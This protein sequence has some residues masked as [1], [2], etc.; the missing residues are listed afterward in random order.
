MQSKDKQAHEQ[1][2]RGIENAIGVISVLSHAAEEAGEGDFTMPAA[3]FGH[4]I[5]AVLDELHR[6]QDANDL[7]HPIVLQAV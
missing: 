2:E 4:A 3:E 7:R 6:A 5:R 1:V